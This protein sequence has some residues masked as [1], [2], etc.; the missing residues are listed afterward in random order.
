MNHLVL[1]VTLCLVRGSST[2]DPAPGVEV[3]GLGYN[4]LKGNPDALKAFESPKTNPT[5]PGITDQRIFDLTYNNGKKASDSSASV[6]DQ[7]Q[8]AAH[9]SCQNE[10]SALYDDAASY[11]KVLQ[12][13]FYAGGFEGGF[14]DTAFAY[15]MG[16]PQDHPIYFQTEKSCFQ[17][18][19]VYQFN[20][21]IL[22][23]GFV[24]SVCKLGTE[25][26]DA[27]IH[28]FLEKYGTHVITGADLGSRELTRYK[29]TL[30]DFLQNFD[31]VI[32]RQ[33]VG[34]GLTSAYTYR[35]GVPTSVL[36]VFAEKI[37]SQVE[38]IF[39]ERKRSWTV[40]GETTAPI[41]YKLVM[42]TS[43]MD[44]N[45]AYWQQICKEA[46]RYSCC[47]GL[48][49]LRGKFYTA[50]RTYAK[51]L[52]VD[53]IQ[54]ADSAWDLR[55]PASTY[56]LPE[57]DV[58]C[59]DSSS[60]NWVHGH[61]LQRTSQYFRSDNVASSGNHFKVGSVS[62]AQVKQYFCMKEDTKGDVK[63]SF[64][65]EMG[66]YC[67]YKGKDECPEYMREGSLLYHDY[68]GGNLKFGSVPAGS[69]A[70]ASTTLR[71]CCRNDGSPTS[72]ILLPSDKPFFLFRHR[73]TCQNVHN[74]DVRLEYISFSRPSWWAMNTLTVG[75]TPDNKITGS[76]M[77]VYYCYYTPRNREI[78]TFQL[79]TE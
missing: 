78:L 28:S 30:R 79:K 14:Q 70:D 31:A 6:P 22:N 2:L 38:E 1:V 65:W 60:V 26:S 62:A 3:V 18:R 56:G 9:V 59:P 49:T 10:R 8:L 44:R 61:T 71:Y 57:T 43:I 32:K 63:S 67:I 4:L 16:L 37:K 7:I 39:G 13:Q 21:A 72:P 69:Y 73:G 55:W 35:L 36:T 68:E 66:S 47:D 5:D 17:S 12:R 50:L 54:A 53:Q 42:L 33:T 51:F 24:N 11:R 41:R 74:M 23:S 20:S 76:D 75:S 45:H 40:G 15:G 64:N 58:G 25:P 29:S 46:G 34:N 48:T 27:D 77:K 52:N 19:A